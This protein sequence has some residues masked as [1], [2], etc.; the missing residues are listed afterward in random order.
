[1]ADE[2]REAVALLRSLTDTIA[3]TL[4]ASA[5]ENNLEFSNEALE[6]AKSSEVHLYRKAPSKASKKTQRFLRE[7]YG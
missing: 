1:M 5:C 6:K 3:A 4:Q 2:A 7:V